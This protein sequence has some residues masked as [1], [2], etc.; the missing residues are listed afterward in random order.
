MHTD[1]EQYILNK[2]IIENASMKNNNVVLL[3]QRKV[4]VDTYSAPYYSPTTICLGTIVRDY[5][6]LP[7][8]LKMCIYCTID[9]LIETV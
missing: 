6:P 5:W 3:V 7:K 9:L 2:L 4:I 8:W 1:L